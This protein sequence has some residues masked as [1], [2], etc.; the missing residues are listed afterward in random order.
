MKGKTII[1][2]VLRSWWVL[3][4][5]SLNGCAMLSN[6][7]TCRVIDPDLATGK[8]HGGC[9][10]GL[11]HGYGEVKGVNTY[12][13]DFRAGKKH[14]QGI[15]VMSNKDRYEGNFQDDLRHGN[16]KYTWAQGSSWGEKWYSGQYRNNWR[17]GWGAQQ[18]VNGDRYEGPW[19]NDMRIYTTTAELRKFQADTAK[20][21]QVG[22]EVCN[23]KPFNADSYPAM[24]GKLETAGL[25]LRIRIT[26]V[27]NDH[28]E[29]YGKQWKVGDVLADDTAHWPLC[30]KN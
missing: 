3:C 12:R 22:A 6:D 23:A 1:T 21:R 11:A 16:G 5:L 15:L 18:W 28:A 26:H 19:E 2:Q 25:Q 4:L 17:H 14:G 13:G 7:T 20:N 24:R 30:G 29:Y 8:Y 10:D 27:P 9:Q